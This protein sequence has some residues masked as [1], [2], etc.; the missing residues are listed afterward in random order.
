M[1]GAVEE[2]LSDKLDVYM[3]ARIDFCGPEDNQLIKIVLNGRDLL[4]AIENLWQLFGCAH[5]IGV[6]PGPVGDAAS[7]QLLQHGAHFLLS[8]PG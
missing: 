5:Q 3:A 6:L 1:I 4:S 8:L 7:W 2:C